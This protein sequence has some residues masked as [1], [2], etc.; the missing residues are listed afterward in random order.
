[1]WWSPTPTHYAVA[2]KYKGE[3]MSAPT[4]VAKGADFL[5]W[6]IREIAAAAGVPIVERSALA[7][8]LYTEVAVGR[9]IPGKFF[10]AVAEILAYV[11]ELNGRNMGPQPVPVGP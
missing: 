3:A 5:A 4:V 2:L 7:R 9:E 11:Y 1:M 8:M 6:R 10:E